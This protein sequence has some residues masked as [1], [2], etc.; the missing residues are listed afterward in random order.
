MK[1]KYRYNEDGT[2]DI[3]RKIT[4]QLGPFQTFYEI[5]EAY[6]PCM[7]E[8]GDFFF[9]LALTT[10][11]FGGHKF[12]TRNYLQGLLY[13]FT[14]GMLGVGYILDLLMIITGCYNYTSTNISRDGS[15]K[16]RT[17]SMPLYNKKQAL[18]ETAIALV[19]VAVLIKILYWPLIVF[20]SQA[21]S[22]IEISLM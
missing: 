13:F 2:V 9:N 17:Y 11:L 14:F 12:Y 18:I 7:T 8:D 20:A 4:T 5:G 1:D 22:Q 16:I 15:A 10:G 21:I 19:A 6:F 3:R